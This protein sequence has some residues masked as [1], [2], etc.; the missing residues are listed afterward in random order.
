MPA[1][2]GSTRRLRWRAASLAGGAVLAVV[3][4]FVALTWL[5][6]VS[7][8]SSSATPVSVITAP[9]STAPTPSVSAHASGLLGPA[10]QAGVVKRGVGCRGRRQ[11]VIGVL[12][13]N[14]RAARDGK[15]DVDLP[16]IAAEIE[17]VRPDLVSLNE[18]D[19]DT[20]RTRADEPAYLARA[21]GLHV[22][23]GPNVIYDGG[24]FGNAILSRY[25]VVAS[26]NLRLPGRSGRESRGLL[27]VVVNVEGHRVVF[28]STHLSNG[29]RGRQS[30]LLQALTVARA[31][32]ETAAPAIL[33]G[34]LNSEPDDVPAR[35][36]RR[37]LLDA[38]EEAGTGKGATYPQASP[39]DRLDYI[40]YGPRLAAVPGSTQVGTSQSSD[41]RSVFTKLRLLAQDS[42]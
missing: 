29:D 11:P 8:D 34:D 13:F 36:L 3:G 35:I 6:V 18:V 30:R 42:C 28:A 10:L 22:V 20:T 24:P 31:L 25:A 23:Y 17:A 26:H 33:A 40:L 21:T 5:A 12:Q 16:Q 1:D 9:L 2:P 4:L 27:T 15:D 14:I 39:T 38:Q 19:S 37:N 7:H 41:H 32:R